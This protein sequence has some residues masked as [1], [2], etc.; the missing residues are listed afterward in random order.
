M[1]NEFSLL[2][3]FFLLFLSFSLVVLFRR[4]RKRIT[5]AKKYF[6]WR[7]RDT[8]HPLKSRMLF[9]E[10][11]L[12]DFEC[13][14]SFDVASAYCYHSLI[15]SFSLVVLFC[16]GQGGRHVRGV[17]RLV[18][19]SGDGSG[20]KTP[21]PSSAPCSTARG[22]APGPS[23]TSARPSWH[24]SWQ[25]SYASGSK[26]RARTVV[27]RL[28]RPIPPRSPQDLRQPGGVPAGYLAGGIAPEGLRRIFSVLPR[29][30]G[31]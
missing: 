9:P 19:S 23:R 11:S 4:G 2:R 3:I 17:H 6:G 30:H 5:F 16:R 20:G 27:A 21:P 7:R 8:I 22:S 1:L 29:D 26:T 15:L 12:I 31:P 18:G 25:S 13:V 24:S 28:T 14:L 10:Y